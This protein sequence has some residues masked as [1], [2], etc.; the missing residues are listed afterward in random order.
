MMRSAGPW[1]LL[2]QNTDWY[3]FGGIKTTNHC[4]WGY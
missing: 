4:D 1:A 2:D 3:R